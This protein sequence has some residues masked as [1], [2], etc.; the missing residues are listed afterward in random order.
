MIK[1]RISNQDGAA[2]SAPTHYHFVVD[3]SGSMHYD[4]PK[5]RQDLQN[6]IGTSLKED[7]LFSLIYYS[8]RGDYGHIVKGFKYSGIDSLQM[9]QNAINNLKSRSLT[10]FV[11]PLNLVHQSVDENLANV[12]VFMSDGYENQ[13]PK[14][15]VISACENLKNKLDAAFIIEYGSRANHDLLVQMSEVIDGTFIYSD[16]IS[17]YNMSIEKIIKSEYTDKYVE[18][19]DNNYQNVFSISNGLVRTYTPQ[20]GVYK[21]PENV[22]L[23]IDDGVYDNA[24]NEAMLGLIYV[25]QMKGNA[26]RVFELLGE[27][28]DVYLIDLYNAAIGKQKVNAFLNEVL[29]CIEDENLRFRNGIDTDYLPAEDQ[30]CLFDFFEDFKRGDNKIFVRHDGFNYNRIGAKRVQTTSVL[31]DEDRQVLSEAVSVADAKAVLDDKYKLNFKYVNA[32]ELGHYLNLD[33]NTKRANISFQVKHD[34]SVDLSQIPNYSG[35]ETSIKTH[36]YRNYAIVKDMVLNVN[37]IVAKLDSSTMDKFLDE[38]LIEKIYE[39]GKVLINLSKMPVVNRAMIKNFDVDDFIELNYQY[40]ESK[41]AMRYLNALKK[42]HDPKK[43]DYLDQYSEE[44]KAWLKEIGIDHNGFNPSTVAVSGNDEY[45]APEVVVKFSK[46]G[47]IPKPSDVI[48][49]HNAGKNLTAREQMLFKYIEKFDGIENDLDKL[50]KVVS[51][52][53]DHKSV[54][55]MQISKSMFQ[56]F[57]TRYMPENDGKFSFE[58]YSGQ[59]LINEKAIKL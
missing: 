38:G 23:H 54:L 28:G 21:V 8:S 36:I 27:L 13:N 12:M 31:S 46:I 30:Y 57:L 7:D 58:D 39:D 42:E 43:A 29:S 19:V 48:E 18:V 20:G 24:D 33:F 5:L 15:E 1:Q 3:V 22:E 4:L 6:L 44:F 10:G 45:Y 35:H 25:E 53:L 41:Y 2:T 16:D 49:K 17:A 32:Q 50:N 52:Y 59:L 11:D 55:E 26:K 47:S 37:H 9:A 56:M 14:K 34:V 51:K 40:L